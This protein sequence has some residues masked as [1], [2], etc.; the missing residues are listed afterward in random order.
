MLIKEPTILNVLFRN[1]SQLHLLYHTKGHLLSRGKILT[2][3]YELIND[4]RIF[5]VEKQSNLTDVFS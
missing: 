4:I 2:R 3:M 1:W 5:L